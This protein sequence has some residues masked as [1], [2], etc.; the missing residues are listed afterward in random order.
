M[1][2][3]YAGGA[4]AAASAARTRLAIA[5]HATAVD[6]SVLLRLVARIAALT[7]NPPRSFGANAGQISVFTAA[8]AVNQLLYA[9]DWAI[10]HTGT[11]GGGGLGGFGPGSGGAA[12][13]ASRAAGG[14][15]GAAS[16]ARA[17]A[18]ATAA[19][20][21]AYASGGSVAYAPVIPT[22]GTVV[23]ID[24]LRAVARR[25]PHEAARLIHG[26]DTLR[27]VLDEYRWDSI[28]MSLDQD[29]Y[30]VYSKGEAIR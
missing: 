29:F 26:M 6:W 11:A 7:L 8:K 28:P 16:V 27:V 20:V 18:A 15:G 25:H 30:A 9:R 10:G 4:N 5:Q 13:A 17:S 1:T 2:S 22:S 21:A 23:D 19:A 14:G 3:S 24:L 12:G